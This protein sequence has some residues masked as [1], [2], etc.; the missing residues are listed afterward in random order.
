MSFLLQNGRTGEQNSSYPG[1][2]G[3]GTSDWGEVEGKEC[4]IVNMVKYY[5]HMYLNI[6]N[7]TCLNYFRNGGIKRKEVKR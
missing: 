3:I 4:R 2:K 6:K 1:A 7:D 5:V